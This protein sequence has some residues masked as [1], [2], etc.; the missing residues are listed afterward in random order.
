MT[1][2]DEKLPELALQILKEQFIDDFD[3]VHP[4]WKTIQRDWEV[5]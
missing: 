3:Q 1:Q 4:Q 2:L 5:H